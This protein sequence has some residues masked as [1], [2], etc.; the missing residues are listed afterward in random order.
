MNRDAPQRPGMNR[1]F[2]VC[3]PH[4]ISYPNYWSS[5]SSFMR[6]ADGPPTPGS[7][8][9]IPGPLM[10]QYLLG[11]LSGMPHQHNHEG[12]A[13]PFAAMFGPENGRWGDYA[14]SQD[15]LDQIM[16]EIME[17]SNA[18]R[19]VPATDE[20]INNLPRD[21]LEEGCT[22]RDHL[23]ILTTLISWTSSSVD[24]EG[25]CC[26]QRAVQSDTLRPR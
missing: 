2:V 26:M 13:S 8:A 21:V 9:E 25:L 12:G 7:P 14:F 23:I 10:A 24:R 15:A 11:L 18:H 6:H 16:T 3:S 22:S 5:L 17:N 19:P 20:I 1:K 4:C